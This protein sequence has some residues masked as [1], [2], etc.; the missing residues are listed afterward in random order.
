MLERARNVLAEKAKETLKELLS[1]IRL[2]SPNSGALISKL[3]F[4]LRDQVRKSRKRR[5]DPITINEQITLTWRLVSG[6]RFSSVPKDNRKRRPINVEPLGNM[7]VQ[8]AIGRSLKEA[9]KRS[10]ND[11][12][13]GQEDHK[14]LITRDSIATIDLSDASDSITWY[15]T[16]LVFPPSI[17]KL[18]DKSRCK[19]SL[20]DRQWNLLRKVSSMGNGFTF[21]LM[22][23]LLLALTRSCGAEVARVYGDDII[24]D[25]KQAHV[26]YDLLNR[27]GFVVNRD[28]SFV[29]GFVRESCG[30]FTHRGSYLMSYDIEWLSNDLD[31]VILA[32]KLYNLKEDSTAPDV[33]RFW[34]RV[35]H[36]V[37]ELLPLSSKGPVPFDRSSS[38]LGDY[39][40][41]N[42]IEE[43]YVSTG[44]SLWIEKA[45]HLPRNS[46]HRVQVLRV[47]PVQIDLRDVPYEGLRKSRLLNHGKLLRLLT[48]APV[49]RFN[50]NKVVC[51]A[52][53]WFCD[54]RGLLY[55][56]NQYKA[57]RNCQP[58][59]EPPSCYGDLYGKG[60]KVRFHDRAVLAFDSA[61]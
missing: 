53:V 22:T 9:L 12:F 17:V 46:V 20:V 52:E 43:N 44:P 27:Y 21:E 14:R 49:Q 26:L 11:L 2:K 57:A 60:D 61:V 13:T 39:V 37:V 58:H 4:R 59:S 48:K 47:H 42:S 32:N 56:R 29:D 8:R 19:Y 51:E 10:G 35:W 55:S 5:P 7:L 15:L 54:R 34:A 41:D 38:C 50:A 30:G 23:T 40:W 28:K 6:G 1:V 31:A 24:V 18:L 16:K 36:R 3:L 33:R 25:V 45:L